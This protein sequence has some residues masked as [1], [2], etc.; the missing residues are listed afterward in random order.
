M[1]LTK[2]KPNKL[3]QRGFTLVEILIAAAIFA[4][5][6]VIA[7][8]LLMS[9]TKAQRRI[10]LLT[11]LQ[12]DTRY[13]M[14]V[15]SQSVRMDGID[16]S[17]YQDS[18]DNGT[19]YTIW[20]PF[21]EKIPYRDIATKDI[22]G[23]RRVFRVVGNRFYPNS[24]Q[25]ANDKNRIYVCEQDTKD[26]AQRGK[27][28]NMHPV[29]DFAVCLLPGFTAITPE[30]IKV[31]EFKVWLSPRSDPNAGPPKSASDCA[32]G[33]VADP[34]NNVYGYDAKNGI[35]TCGVCFVEQKCIVPSGAS[36][37]RCV[38]PDRQPRITFFITTETVSDKAEERV[39]TTLQTT[40]TSRTYKR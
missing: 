37:A 1:K 26:P 33:V 25:C 21:Y 5:V 4:T 13:V 6:V 28:R 16:Y 38:A 29:D 9:T 23:I 8:G 31:L 14:D 39:Q 20:F 34:A 24:N 2:L 12:G 35:C 7:V 3:T 10:Q 40:V 30:N 32:T 36:I 15:I 27:C 17:Y 18:Y 22:N 11:K 19:T